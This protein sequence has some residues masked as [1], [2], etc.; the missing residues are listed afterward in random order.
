VTAPPE[1]LSNFLRDRYAL[2]RELGR[3]GMATVYLAHDQYDFY[4]PM[5]TAQKPRLR[6]LGTPADQKR[7]VVEDGS[8]YVPRTRLIQ[9]TLAWL[10]RYQRVA[11]GR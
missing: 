11:D 4:F 3:G 5:E 2:E 1:F 10:D 7:Y 6:L 8:H 9:E